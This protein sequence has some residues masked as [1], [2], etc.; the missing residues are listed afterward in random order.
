MRVR[1]ISDRC[2]EVLGISGFCCRTSTIY[3]FKRFVLL[4]SSLAAI[5]TSCRAL[6]SDKI[7]HCIDALGTTALGLPSATTGLIPSATPVLGSDPDIVYS[8]PSAWTISES[9]SN[10]TTSK[11]L[12]VT[13]TINATVSF[14]FTGKTSNIKDKRQ[15]DLSFF[16]KARVLW[17]AQWRLQMEVFSQCGSTVLTPPPI[18]TL[19]PNV[20][21]TH[22]RSAIHCSFLRLRSLLPDLR[23]IPITPWCWYTLALQRF[24][25]AELA[26]QFSSTHSL[27]LIPDQP[28]I[29]S[30]AT[31][32]TVD[33]ISLSHCCVFSSRCLSLLCSS[34]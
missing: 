3:F 12:H 15:Y 14:N 29:W 32:L 22:S 31:V 13:D 5:G 24:H 25:R 28:S 4:I 11:S 6:Q 7:V 26:I 34:T 2:D 1:I 9:D 16:L 23:P 21:V 8:P 33:K 30:T 18:S 27:Y 20:E 10:C 19:L 17:S